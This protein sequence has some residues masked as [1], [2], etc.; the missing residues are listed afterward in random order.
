MGKIKFRRIASSKALELAELEGFELSVSYLQDKLYHNN[1][2]EWHKI[3]LG[4]RVIGLI[5]L[6]PEKIKLDFNHLSVFEIH[7]DFQNRGYGTFTME[8]L[9]EDSQEQYKGFTLQAREPSLINF[10][11]K[12]GF[13]LVEDTEFIRLMSKEFH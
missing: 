10:Y 3:L 9:L 1:A 7:K 13:E 6:A 4:S 8:Y 2:Y 12:L 11:K 5:C